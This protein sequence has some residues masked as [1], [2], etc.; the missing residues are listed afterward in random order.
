MAHCARWLL[1]HDNLGGERAAPHQPS[2]AQ[3]KWRRLFWR[4]AA[5]MSLACVWHSGTKFRSCVPKSEPVCAAATKVVS[6]L[7]RQCHYSTGFF[8]PPSLLPLLDSK[9]KV[10]QTR[11][12]MKYIWTFT[13]ICSSFSVGSLWPDF[14]LDWILNSFCSMYFFLTKLGTE[15]Y[16]SFDAFQELLRISK[17]QKIALLK[18]SLIGWI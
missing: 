10:W 18:S 15:N 5:G 6:L 2:P 8:S 13:C 11:S 12:Q 7:H 9:W 4:L 1:E 3:H 16:F 17:Y 14:F